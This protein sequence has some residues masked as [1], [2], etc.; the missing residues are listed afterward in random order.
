MLLVCSVWCWWWDCIN[1]PA[2]LVRFSTS[3]YQPFPP[4]PPQNCVWST[5]PA[6]NFG[7]IEGYQGNNIRLSKHISSYPEILLAVCVQAA[8]FWNVVLF[9]LLDMSH[10]FRGTCWSTSRSEVWWRQQVRLRVMLF[11]IIHFFY[12][13]LSG[14]MVGWIL[15]VMF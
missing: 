1:R 14:C 4:V 9:S 11:K 12:C 15:D 5:N 2:A 7:T 13:T 6:V 10:W 3:S 8:V